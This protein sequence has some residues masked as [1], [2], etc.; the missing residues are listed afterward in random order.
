MRLPAYSL[1]KELA[2]CRELSLKEAE[3]LLLPPLFKD[4]RDWYPVAGL[5]RQGYIGDP[6]ANSPGTPLSERE[7]ASMLF[8]KTLG[9]GSHKIN[10]VTAVNTDAE[11]IQFY[12]T[13][14]VDLYFAE[15]KAKRIDRFLS[16]FV[17]IVIGVSSA[18]LT[19]YV[20]GAI[21]HG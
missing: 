7:L 9:E 3:A 8:G 17:A 14:K 1:L 2:A 5:I 21:G 15:L 11:E 10:N 16:A 12:A 19:L 20:K 4:F 6:F 13:S 18:T